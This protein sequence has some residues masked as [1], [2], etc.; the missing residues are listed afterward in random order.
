MTEKPQITQ[1]EAKLLSILQRDAS[2]SVADLAEATHASAA[3]VWRRIRALEERGV[4]GPPVRLVDP[5][6]VGRGMDVYCQVR[7]K[8]QDAEAR[9]AFQRAIDAE[10]AIMEV[11]SVTGEW[12]YM[13]HMVVRDI[14]DFESILMRRLLELDCVAGTS[15]IFA[16][17]R[18]KHT[19]EVPL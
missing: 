1:P 19:R 12:D 9:A 13:L 15:T 5:A 10:P 14:A 11:Y 8:S 4:I 17:R 16:L 6:Q 3:T 7:M 2:A 18:I